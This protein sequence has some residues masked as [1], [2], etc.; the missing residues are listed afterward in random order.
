MTESKVRLCPGDSAD[1]SFTSQAPH[2]PCTICDLR[3]RVQELER[4]GTSESARLSKLVTK[5][6]AEIAR[7]REALEAQADL[8]R[9]LA[10]RV[11]DDIGYDIEGLRG[12]EI[13]LGKEEP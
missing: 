6:Q 10:A 3:A 9:G 5:Y 4:M 11:D 1:W 12:A 8:Y 7:L 2:F 13:L